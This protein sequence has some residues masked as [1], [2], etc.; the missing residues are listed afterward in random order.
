MKYC[1]TCGTE[2]KWVYWRED[3]YNTINGS[4]EY[5][6]LLMCPK[7]KSDGVLKTFF[8]GHELYPTGSFGYHTRTIQRGDNS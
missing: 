5:Q 7:A 6:E 8:T 1:G 2:L 3:G 4:K